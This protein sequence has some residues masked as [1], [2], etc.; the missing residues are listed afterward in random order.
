MDTGRQAYPTGKNGEP[1]TLEEQTTDGARKFSPSVGR[2]RDVVREALLDNL[3]A[4]AEILE[5]GSGT[6]E[7]GIYV[8]EAAA[9]MQWTFTDHSQDA[10]QGI[11]AWIEYAARENLSGPYQLD[12]SEPDW[13][14]DVE[15]KQY[16]AIF[17]ANVVH[18]SPFSVT[19][20]LFTGAKRLLKPDGQLV[21]YGPFS[22]NG[23][24]APSNRR[25]D[26]D[27]KKRDPEWGI[28]DIEN[29][30]NILAQVNGLKLRLAAGMPA[31]NLM[32]FFSRA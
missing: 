7:H 21:F 12:V 22:R 2:N 28:R 14:A 25:F 24:M 11:S 13:G 5:I 18:I 31:N 9:E 6:G 27:L 26:A 30:L 32:L 29:E 19:R 10:L 17:S 20:G 3:P 16:D 23:K 4:S 8:T 1:R 15:G